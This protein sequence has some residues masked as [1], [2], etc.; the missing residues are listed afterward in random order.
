MNSYEMGKIV[1]SCLFDQIEFP[2][3]SASE[4]QSKLKSVMQVFDSMKK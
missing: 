4:M 2:D 3:N 1:H